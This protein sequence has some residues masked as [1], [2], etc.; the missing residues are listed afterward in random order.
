MWVHSGIRAVFFDAVGTLLFPRPSAPVVYAGVALKYGLDLSPADV[1]DRFI[2]AYRAEEAIDS[3]TG[4]ATSEQREH[5]RWHRIVTETLRG[6]ADP[7]ACFRE[8]FDHFAMPSAWG[9]NPD[10]STVLKHLT[11]RGIVVGLGSNYDARLWPVLD[12]FPEL[13][14]LRD[15]VVVSA[16]TGYRKPAREFF[17][18][19]CRVAGCEPAAVLFVG[20][21][22]ENDYDGAANAGLE[23]LLLGGTNRP[24]RI[25]S[26]RELVT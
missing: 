4:W 7:D 11:D 8:L 23:P 18:E 16:S 17:A 25:A 2:A 13:R 5:D 15:R 9:V 21:D 22:M 3:A 10:S 26:L 1:R 12:G 6:V 20:D 19:V 24:R 14:P